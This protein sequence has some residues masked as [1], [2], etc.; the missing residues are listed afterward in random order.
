MILNNC[1]LKELTLTTTANEIRTSCGLDSIEH[2]VDKN[3]FTNYPTPVVY[4]Y[5]SL[6]YRDQEWPTDVSN[7][8]WCVGDSFTA[9]LGQRYENIWPQLVEQKINTRTINVSMHGASNDWISRR[10]RYILDNFNP[11]SILIQWSYLH[12]R[13]FENSSHID[14]DRAAQHDP[15]D[16]NDLENFSKNLYNV[17][18]PNVNIVH[19]FIPKFHSLWGERP[20]DQQIYKFLTSC[21][22]SYFQ[23]PA[24][25]DFSRDGHHYDAVTAN[26]YADLYIDK[27]HL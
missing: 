8:I 24:Q 26:A 13:E 7:Q 6:G 4:I 20:V 16:T 5:N 22:V 27:L 12:R 14:E 9:G 2:C 18:M 23:P 1:D 11:K 21:N 17:M 3:H 10:V 19:S 15:N 25:V